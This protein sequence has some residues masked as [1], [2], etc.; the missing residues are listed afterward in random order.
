VPS[1]LLVSLDNGR[2]ASCEK[3]LILISLTELALKVGRE[4]EKLGTYRWPHGIDRQ[5]RLL[6]NVIDEFVAVRREQE[7]RRHGDAVIC[8]GYLS[9]L[10]RRQE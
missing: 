7:D 10:V 8:I 3:S 5:S 1:I 4:Y 9:V 2:K 6:A